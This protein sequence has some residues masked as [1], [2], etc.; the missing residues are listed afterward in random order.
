MIY[1]QRVIDELSLRKFGQKGW[2]GSSKCS[3]PKC[4]KADKFGI[5]LSN[6]G[7]SIHCMR[8]DH[9]A[10]IYTYL[11]SIDKA[12][13]ISSDEVVTSFKTQLTSPF[14]KTKD[15]SEIKEL[16]T[17]KR[18]IG[19]IPVSENDLYLKRRKF[20]KKHYE[21]FKPGYSG[22]APNITEDH[23]I[24]LIYQKKQ[25][26]TWLARSRHSY[27]WH[28][29][30]LQDFKDDKG[31]LILRYYN[32]TG[33]ELS[34]ILGGYDEITEKTDTIILVEG[35]FDKVSVDRELDLNN[36]DEVKCLFT[37]G[38]KISPEQI[39]LIKETNVKNIILFYDSD[40]IKQ[41]K[42]T[43]LKLLHSNFDTKIAEIKGSKDPG[44]M[45]Y[46]EIMEIFSNLRNSL[47]FY[48]NKLVT[49]FGKKNV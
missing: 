47:Y 41:S 46:E 37:F 8:C 44:E 17:V 10:S 29:K 49:T 31:D 12:H 27:Q 43:G 25:L 24:F 1:K 32:Y 9:K 15:K 26:V 11:R 48:T 40:A 34:H 5:Y 20:T 13:L 2:H 38:N 21:L 36:Y 39:D 4:G 23:I 45:N 22:L 6:Q 35:L 33:T 30:N 7:G 28:A 14:T 16:F 18:P 3:C 19:Y 42:S